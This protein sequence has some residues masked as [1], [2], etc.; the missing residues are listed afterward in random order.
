M[1]R[2]TRS[3]GMR[4]EVQQFCEGRLECSSSLSS[5]LGKCC[6]ALQKSII[7][8]PVGNGYRDTANSDSF[9]AQVFFD[10]KSILPNANK[11][12]TMIFTESEKH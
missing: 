1:A 10:R 11:L 5:W 6:P 8:Q 4:S 7:Y 12:S 2:E 3:D 9:F